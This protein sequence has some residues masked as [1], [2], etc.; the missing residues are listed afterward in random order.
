MKTSCICILVFIILI[1]G[2]PLKAILKKDYKQMNLNGFVKSIVEI[3]Y[4]VNEKDGKIIRDSGSIF[5]FAPTRLYFF[6]GNGNLTESREE[7]QEGIP[8]KT[9]FLYDD[10][11]NEIENILYRHNREK[12]VQDTT[13][14][15]YDDNGNKIEENYSGYVKQKRT[16]LYDDKGHLIEM[17]LTTFSS[18]GN[19][20]NKTVYKYEING[21]MVEESEYRS[22]GEFMKNIK[23]SFDEKG[24]K[25]E[26]QEF[27]PEGILRFKSTYKY[28]EM[29]N[30][31][32]ENRFGSTGN[33]LK[34]TTNNYEYDIHNNWIKLLIFE[35]KILKAIAERKIEYYK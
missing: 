8:T 35:N 31:I 29:N 16:Y 27:K 19:V 20:N 22:T 6:D 3:V 24:N 12:E 28:D 1:S 30:T 26:D 9:V 25:T 15:R 23:Y 17:N 32:E 18:R 14:S 2:S 10:K 4:G 7:Y 13:T 34:S 5:S 33:I 11:G 21:N